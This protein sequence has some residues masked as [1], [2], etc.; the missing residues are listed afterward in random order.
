MKN[1]IAA[2]LLSLL[3]YNSYSSSLP[4]SQNTIVLIDNTD[5]TEYTVT[6]TDAS[7]ASLFA[8][9]GA[10]TAALGTLTYSSE[11]ERVPFPREWHSIKAAYL[12]SIK[13][14]LEEENND[15]TVLITDNSLVNDLPALTEKHHASKVY[16]LHNTTTGKTVH[17]PLHINYTINSMDTSAMAGIH[18]SM[19]EVDPHNNYHRFQKYHA[20]SLKNSR[21]TDCI[22]SYTKDRERVTQE[23]Y[24]DLKENGYS[25]E[26]LDI[27]DTLSNDH[28]SSVE[29]RLVIDRIQ[30]S[31]AKD[32][33]TRTLGC[34]LHFLQPILN[35]LSLSDLSESVEEDGW[36]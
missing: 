7:S 20:V 28:I 19:T 35:T 25:Q 10:I 22:N 9:G 12:N 36:N 23:Y 3:S 27:D 13:E 31:K 32:Y 6:L 14:L 24:L 33:P 26:E 18:L 2:I 4:P 8:L 21:I 30:P 29:E 5:T 17:T 34:M 15:A 16:I 1:A 11:S